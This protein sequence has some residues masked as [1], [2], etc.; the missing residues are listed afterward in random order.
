MRLTEKYGI[1]EA[2]IKAMYL[3][4]DLPCGSFKRD[5][6]LASYN[7]FINQG[8]KKSKAIQS[9]SD[10]VGCSLQYVY[11]VINQY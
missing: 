10:E 4:G 9:A 6:I 7:K 1:T 2:Q 11:Q 5:E 3:G 8:L